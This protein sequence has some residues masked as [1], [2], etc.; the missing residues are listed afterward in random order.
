MTSRLRAF[1]GKF[2]RQFWVATQDFQ[3]ICD[4]VLSTLSCWLST[5]PQFKILNPVVKSIPVLVV[6]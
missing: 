5:N 1:A 3:G 2:F 4:F 6:N